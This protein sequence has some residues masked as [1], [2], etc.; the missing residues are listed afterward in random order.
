MRVFFVLQSSIHICL[1]PSQTW[2]Y[3]ICQESQNVENHGS[4][5]VL[6][7]ILTNSNLLISPAAILEIFLLDTL[8]KTAVSLW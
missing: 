1:P 6:G 7:L 2:E 5:E 4:R 8:G 3:H